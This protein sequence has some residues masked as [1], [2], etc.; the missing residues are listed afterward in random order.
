MLLQRQ[1]LKRVAS[2]VVVFL[3]YLA[4]EEKRGSLDDETNL[5]L[6]INNPDRSALRL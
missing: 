6:S 3:L 2:S 1:C 5:A 4:P